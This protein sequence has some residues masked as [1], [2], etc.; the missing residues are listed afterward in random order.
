[1]A[2][3]SDIV[4]INPPGRE[5]LGRPNFIIEAA[6]G[7]LYLTVAVLGYSEA[8]AGDDAARR[9][10]VATVRRAFEEGV[11]N[12]PLRACEVTGRGDAFAGPAPM[13]EDGPPGMNTD[14]LGMN[15]QP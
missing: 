8:A 9:E 10:G 11:A 5:A 12:A 1:M 7:T 4:T 6:D 15:T 3:S 14:P 13:D 2:T